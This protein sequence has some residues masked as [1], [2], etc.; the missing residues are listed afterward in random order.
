MF[1]RYFPRAQTQR[2][3]KHAKAN[4]C[5]RV[6]RREREEFP[7]DLNKIFHAPRQSQARAAFHELSAMWGQ[8]FPSAV[9]VIEKDFDALLRFFQLTRPLDGFENDPSD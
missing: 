7:K 6:R 8:S 4:A 2:C 1:S 3:Q 9:A 5:R